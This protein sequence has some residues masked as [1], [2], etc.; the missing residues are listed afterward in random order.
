V[1]YPYL[2]IPFLKVGVRHKVFQRKTYLSRRDRK[3]YKKTLNLLSGPTGRKGYPFLQKKP[4]L[5]SWKGYPFLQKM[6]DKKKSFLKQKMLRIFCQVSIFCFK[7]VFFLFTF[8]V[9]NGIF[10]GTQAKPPFKNS[11]FVKKRLL[12]CCFTE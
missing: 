11:I 10:E 5:L 3:G 7:K 8:F 1:S 9:S 2:Q 6:F 12:F 4:Y